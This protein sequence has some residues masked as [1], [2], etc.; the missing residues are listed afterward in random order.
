MLASSN[1]NQ[2]SLLSVL[3]GPHVSWLGPRTRQS[4]SIA[5][6]NRNGNKNRPERKQPPFQTQKSQNRAMDKPQNG[7]TN[8]SK[9]AS[10]SQKQQVW[11]P[12]S[13][14]KAEKNGLD[15]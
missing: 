12:R 13:E 10:T 4:T 5:P 8:G 14:T 6:N 7:E 2:A 1:H 11:R 15:E 3:V 9:H